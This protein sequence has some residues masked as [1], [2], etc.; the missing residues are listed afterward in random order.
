MENRRN[1]RTTAMLR[2]LLFKDGL[3]VAIGRTRDVSDGGVFVQTDYADFDALRP[4]EME[5]L[6]NR[7]TRV[8]GNGRYR[9]RLIHKTA[10]GFGLRFDDDNKAKRRAITIAVEKFLDSRQVPAQDARV[11]HKK[12]L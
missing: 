6:S 12:R 3:P 11:K 1:S 2:I 4:V 8:G 7:W 5:L 10:D 9:G